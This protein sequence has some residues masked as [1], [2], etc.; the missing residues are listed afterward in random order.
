MSQLREESIP[1]ESTDVSVSMLRSGYPYISDRLR[2]W[3]T[4][5]FQARLLGRPTVF[6]RGRSAAQMFYD[7]TKFT[8]VGAI[9]PPVRGTLFGKGTVHG[10]DGS[11]HHH[12]KAMFL[13]LLDDE[14]TAEITRLTRSRWQRSLPERGPRRPIVL[15][16]ESVR[17]LAGAVSEWAGM[18]VNH[19]KFPGH[20]RDLAMIVDGF[21]SVGLRQI[22]ARMARLRCRAWAR[23]Y[24]RAVRNGT[25]APRQ[26]TAV[27]VIARHRDHRNRRLP[28][29]TAADELLN[30]LRPTVAVAW[31]VTFAALALHDHPRWR[32]PLAAGD[33]QAVRAFTQEVR[34]FFPFAPA[35]AAW[36]RREF[37]WRGH[38]FR[39][40]TRVVLDLYGTNHDPAIWR[41]AGYFDPSRF[42]DWEP[43]AFELIPQGGGEPDVGHRCPGEPLTIALLEQAVTVL[44]R[45]RT[46]WAAQRLTYSLSR[47]PSRVSS[48]VVLLPYDSAP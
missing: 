45:T 8:R 44:A 47:I 18:A 43:D 26:D 15:F 2:R 37:V 22:R 31:F 11:A 35:L 40:G 39:R 23:S 29:D 16:D 30:I 6:L 25:L 36:P 21:G 33:A 5:A 27:S 32:E 4:E 7:N 17:I 19:P 28:L 34:R 46:R 12:R 10:L 38:G 13:G 42:V 48:G 1:V 9:P 41:D 14:A 24:I 20:A 3:G